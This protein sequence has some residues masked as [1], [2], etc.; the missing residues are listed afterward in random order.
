[1]ITITRDKIYSSPF[2]LKKTNSNSKEV[3][4][5]QASDVIKFLGEE[6]EL[7]NDV[8]FK[9]LFDIIILHKDFLNVLFSKEMRELMIDDFIL[10][11]ERDSVSSFNTEDFD[12]RLSW[13]SDVFEYEKEIEYVEYVAFEAFGMLEEDDEE[14]YPISIAFVPLC[15]IK[16]KL[17][18]LD[19]TFEIHDEKSIEDELGAIFKANYRAFTL[20][21]IF[22][23]ILN[24][25]TFYGKPDERE[26]Q[27]KEI[28]NRM[29]NFNGFMS[30]SEIGDMMGW[31]E[32]S[33][34]IDSVNE[35]NDYVSF[36][37]VLYPPE[38]LKE[39]KTEIKGKLLVFS[40][41]SEKPLEVQLQEAHDSEDYETAAKIKKLIDRR[42]KQKK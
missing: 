20:Y 11:Y 18:F 6:V 26:R 9:N 5:I 39:E 17:V 40:E 27:V 34:E 12:M 8:T 25:I 29:D 3:K 38:E 4:E 28:Q 21:D 30:D 36:W 2:S 33:D 31:S 13:Q 10:D 19:Y 14:K 1:M 42:N 22:S 23:S 15:D 16:N 37:D 35:D 41:I 24:E 32:L 7:G